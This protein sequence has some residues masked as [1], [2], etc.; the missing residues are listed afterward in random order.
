MEISFNT[1]KGVYEVGYSFCDED[2]VDKQLLDTLPA[3]REFWSVT[4]SHGFNEGG[5][6]NIHTFISSREEGSTEQELDGEIENHYL[7]D[8]KVPVHELGSYLQYLMTLQKMIQDR[9]ILDGESQDGKQ[10]I[11]RSKVSKAKVG[12]GKAKAKVGK[13]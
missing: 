4:Q 12:K 8:V 3:G 6:L 13:K 1:S 5:E 10:D 7:I 2:N 9:M 11:Q